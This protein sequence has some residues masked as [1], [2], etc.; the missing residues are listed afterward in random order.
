MQASEVY[1]QLKVGLT[2]GVGYKCAIDGVTNDEEI[3]RI[4]ELIRTGRPQHDAV[5]ST[6]ASITERGEVEILLPLCLPSWQKG[7]EENVL[8][9]VVK[10]QVSRN[11]LLARLQKKREGR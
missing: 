8:R 2:K 3:E 4:R 5:V 10:Y 7:I 1:S 11:R 6:A 9:N